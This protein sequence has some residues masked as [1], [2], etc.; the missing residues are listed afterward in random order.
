MAEHKEEGNKSLTKTSETVRDSSNVIAKEEE[1]H[2]ARKEVI[3]AFKKVDPKEFKKSMEKLILQKMTVPGVDSLI[4]ELSNYYREI[5]RLRAPTRMRMSGMI[6]T[7]RRLN[8][9]T[10]RQKIEAS[11]DLRKHGS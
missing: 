10:Q 9:H 5:S 7:A 6:D 4:T 11:E 2:P 3:S 1:K 8:T